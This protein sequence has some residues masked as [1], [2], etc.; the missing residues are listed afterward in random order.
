MKPHKGKLVG[1]HR[2]ECEDTR[3]I[4]RGYFDGHPQFHGMYGHTSEVLCHD[5]AT[6]EIETRNSRYTL[7]GEPVIK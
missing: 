3:Y 1:W 2:H 5:E 4:I 7:V 6:G